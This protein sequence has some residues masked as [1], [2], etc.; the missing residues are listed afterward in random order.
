MVLAMIAAMFFIRSDETRA[1]VFTAMFFAM[2]LAVALVALDDLHRRHEKVAFRPRTRMGW[3]AI[4][5]SV[6]GVATMFLSGLYVAIIRTGQP[7]EMGPF[8]PM[9]VFTIA[10][11]ALMLAAGVVSLLAWFRSDE[12]SWLVLLPLLPAL[13]AVHFV[14]GEFTF[15]H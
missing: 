14:V 5:L 3:W 9:L 8:I 7:T 2:T 12:R 15:P 6:A 10:G 13:F 4:G 11:F 1:W